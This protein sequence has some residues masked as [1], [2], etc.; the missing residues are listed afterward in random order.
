MYKWPRKS[1]RFREVSVLQRCPFN[2][3]KFT[4]LVWKIIIN[5]CLDSWLYN[6]GT[7]Q[8]F[9]YGMFNIHVEYT[10]FFFVESLIRPTELRFQFTVRGFSKCD[11]TF[12]HYSLFES[13]TLFEY[14]LNITLTSCSNCC[15]SPSEHIAG[16]ASDFI[17]SWLGRQNLAE[18]PF[19]SSQ[20]V[21][22]YLASF[23][24]LSVSESKE[25]DKTFRT[26]FSV[27]VGVAI[28]PSDM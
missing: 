23:D 24:M 22:Y 10:N 14:Y 17:A 26:V 5:V 9:N 12:V 4:V 1:V 15:S 13:Y 18:L 7:V 25:S 6:I 2:K 27:S 21:F 11:V 3:R 28:C 16:W 20:L 8:S 19:E